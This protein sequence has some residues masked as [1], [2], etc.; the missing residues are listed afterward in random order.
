MHLLKIKK[1][2]MLRKII[3]LMLKELEVKLHKMLVNRTNWKRKLRKIKN[4]LL[5]NQNLQLIIRKGLRNLLR[6]DK[7]KNLLMIK[8]KI[9]RNLLKRVKARINLLMIKR[10]IQKRQLKK[11]SVKTN[12]WSQSMIKRQIRNRRSNQQNKLLKSNNN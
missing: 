4:H 3:Q 9:Q 7:A 2:K 5:I 10:K 1:I 12:Q 11:Q 8:R 6:K